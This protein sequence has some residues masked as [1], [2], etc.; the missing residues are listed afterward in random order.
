[1][2][3]YNDY[4]VTLV[5]EPD[6]TMKVMVTGRDANHAIVKA[7]ALYEPLDILSVEPAG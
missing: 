6:V 5:V 2:S 3:G 1:M 7:V 4:D